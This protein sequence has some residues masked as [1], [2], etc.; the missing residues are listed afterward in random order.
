MNTEEISTLCYKLIDS[1]KIYN[2]DIAD[3]KLRQEINETYEKRL[4][5]KESLLNQK[6]ED[7]KNKLIIISEQNDWIKKANAEIKT[8]ETYIQAR[9]EELKKKE[10][11][12]KLKRDELIKRAE[13]INKKIEQYKE[14][15]ALD[16]DL[17]QRESI[18]EKEKILDHERKQILDL[19]ENKIKSLEQELQRIT[20]SLK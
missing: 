10:S 5:G 1:L 18:I 20:D 12:I 2:E 6:V 8:R 7:I 13:N 17:K 4:M 3:I 14:L 16:K 19:R 15:D 9:L 11:D